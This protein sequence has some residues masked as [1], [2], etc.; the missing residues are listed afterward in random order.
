MSTAKIPLVYHKRLKIKLYQSA[1]I[2][3]AY[4]SLQNG[5]TNIA[6]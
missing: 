5:K 1:G 3:K 4:K 2:Y 6:E